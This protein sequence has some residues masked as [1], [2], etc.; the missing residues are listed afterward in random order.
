MELGLWGERGDSACPNGDDCPYLD[1]GRL[2]GD[3]GWECREAFYRRLGCSSVGKG[4]H[5]L[6]ERLSPPGL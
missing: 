1:S 2:R 4:L 6:D 3:C 5:D